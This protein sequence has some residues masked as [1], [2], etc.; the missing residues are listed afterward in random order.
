MV[1]EILEYFFLVRHYHLTLCNIPEKRKPHLQRKLLAFFTALKANIEQGKALSFLNSESYH[2][3][4][5]PG[6]SV[7]IATDYGLDGPGIEFRVG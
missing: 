3:D 5:G 1:Q 6:S 7:S 4:I 2:E